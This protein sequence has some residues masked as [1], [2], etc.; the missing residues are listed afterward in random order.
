MCLISKAK[1]CFRM[2]IFSRIKL[3]KYVC[4]AKMMNN[5]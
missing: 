4:Y 1:E 5:K 2:E 3:T